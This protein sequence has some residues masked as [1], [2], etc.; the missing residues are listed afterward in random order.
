MSVTGGGDTRPMSND[1]PLTISC[2]DCTARH[3]DACSDCIVTFLCDRDVDD[4]LVID[5][6]EARAMRALADAGLVPHLRLVR[7]PA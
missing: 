4:A 5:V 6:E 1:E 3:T 2:D 7:K